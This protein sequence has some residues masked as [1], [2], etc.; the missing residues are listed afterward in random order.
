MPTITLVNHIVAREG[1]VFIHG[2]PSEECVGCRFRAV[3]VDKLKPN[4]LYEVIRVTGIRNPCRLYGYVTTVEVEEKPVVLVIPKR[5]ALEG[6]KF[7]YTPVNCGEKK[8]PYFTTC[9]APYVRESLPVRVVSVRGKVNCRA[10][11][12]SM[13]AAEVVLAD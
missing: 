11:K 8:C 10:S 1:H 5:L 2:K 6:L 4:H 12:E 3:C 7:V 9:N 13:V